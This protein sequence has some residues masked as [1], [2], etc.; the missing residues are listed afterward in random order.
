MIEP[1]VVV[2]KRKGV[3]WNKSKNAVSPG[4]RAPLAIW[5]R[6]VEENKRGQT[7]GAFFISINACTQKLIKRN[8]WSMNLG[9]AAH[10]AFLRKSRKK[11]GFGR[12]K[13]YN[14]CL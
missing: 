14:S 3:F 9:A 11:E 6:S 7:D 5:F 2:T 10:Y 4:F 1:V 12:N 13:K 8:K